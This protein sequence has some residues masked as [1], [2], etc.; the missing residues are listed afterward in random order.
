VKLIKL[1]LSERLIGL[2]AAEG[3]AGMKAEVKVVEL[4]NR[5]LSAILDE[6]AA[7]MVQNALEDKGIAFYLNNTVKEIKGND[8][9]TE[10]YSKWNG[11]GLRCL[12][13]CDRGYPE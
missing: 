8:R 11:A 4:A 12:D 7:S 10:L 13:Y 9:V 6:E 3:L 1:S 2:K 5:V